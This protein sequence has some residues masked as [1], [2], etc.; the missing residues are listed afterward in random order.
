MSQR[1]L[2]FAVVLAAGLGCLVEWER[3]QARRV[4]DAVM[5]LRT[6]QFAPTTRA[7]LGTWFRAVEPNT[8]L[9]W[10]AE[11]TRLMD[12]RTVVELVT[13][14]GEETRVYRFSVDIDD[15]DARPLDA[16]TEALV[17]RVTRW[18]LP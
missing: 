11:P 8:Q 4:D 7:R 6:A 2:G 17:K 15:R 3:A 13:R 9:T 10:R 18:A 1:M 5:A 14:A 12:D 16:A